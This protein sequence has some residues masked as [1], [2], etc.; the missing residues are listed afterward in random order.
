MPDK[1]RQ[2]E[3]GKERKEKE[4]GRSR[5][6]QDTGH[7]PEMTKELRELHAG[8]STHSDE[9]TAVRMSGIMCHGERPKYNQA[10]DGNPDNDGY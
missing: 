2:D 5:Y 9:R 10:N 6:F 8:L 4:W 3:R 1:Y 7:R